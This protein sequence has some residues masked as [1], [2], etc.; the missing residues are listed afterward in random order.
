MLYD[1]KL[2]DLRVLAD[3]E[4]SLVSLATKADEISNQL[5]LQKAQF[6]YLARKADAMHRRLLRESGRTR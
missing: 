4:A 5:V 2:Y 1:L 3:G 6:D